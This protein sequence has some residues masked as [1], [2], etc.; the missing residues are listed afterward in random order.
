M[1]PRR[2]LEAVRLAGRRSPHC[3]PSPWATPSLSRLKKRR[4]L[5]RENRSV[6]LVC[7]TSQLID[8]SVHQSVDVYVDS[9][10]WGESLI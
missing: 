4:A 8:P 6:T 7:R 5:K 1:D 9:A 10:H 3:L 2:V